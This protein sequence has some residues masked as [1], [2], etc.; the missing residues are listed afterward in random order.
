M[1]MLRTNNIFYPNR[2]ISVTCLIVLLYE[3]LSKQ[4]IVLFQLE[5]DSLKLPSKCQDLT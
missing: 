3:N 5:T 2:F 1:S 4:G